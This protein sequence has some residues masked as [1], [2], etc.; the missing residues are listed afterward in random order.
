MIVADTG[1]LVAL[2]DA[3]DRHHERCV[4]WFKSTRSPLLVPSPVLTEVCWLLD[5]SKGSTAEA[6]FLRAIADP[7]GPL[8][9][10]PL[11]AE[12]LRRMAD[13][14]ERYG[15]LPLGAVDASVIAVAERLK[16]T[17]VA[18]LDVRHFSVVRPAHVSHFVLE[19][20]PP[21]G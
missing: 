12:D 2:L 8:V 19:P 14:V 18:T 1:P 7:T 17:S 6:A 3:D 16:V 10:V 20:T 21:F 15:D 5:R 13:L 11:G 9:L 4:D